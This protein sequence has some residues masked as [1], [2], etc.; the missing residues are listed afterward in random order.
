MKLEQKNALALVAVSLPFFTIFTISMCMLILVLLYPVLSVIKVPIDP[1][2]PLALIAL[3]G[4][5]LFLSSTREENPA[6]YL[7]VPLVAALGMMALNPILTALIVIH[8]P[9]PPIWHPGIL[10]SLL[11]GAGVIFLLPLGT[12]LFFWSQRQ[13]VRWGRRGSLQSPCWWP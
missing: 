10:W 3:C 13:R 8:D 9:S 5:I 7:G 4:G 2:G 11:A 6:W 1:M 12:A